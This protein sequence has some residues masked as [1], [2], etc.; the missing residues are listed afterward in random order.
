MRL[1]TFFLDW[2]L[3]CQFAGPIWAR[4][5]G[6]YRHQGLE[7]KLLPPSAQTQ[8]SL[9]DLVLDRED[10]V[11]SIEDNLIVRAALSRKPVRAI[12]CMLN[13]TPLV[14]M[15]AL[16]GPIKTLLD[17]PGH[18][19]AMHGD[20]VHLLKTLLKLNGLDL[21]SVRLQADH[22]SLDNLIEGRLD[23]LQGYAITEARTLAEQGFE[24]RL[25]PLRHPDLNPHSQV[26]FASLQTIA[27][28]KK[29]LQA[30]LRATFEGWRQVLAQP[31][32]AAE[33]IAEHSSEHRDPIQNWVILDTIGRY[34]SAEEASRPL[35]TLD[36]ERWRRN[37]KS[38]ARCGIAAQVA[39]INL[40]IEPHLFSH[41]SEQ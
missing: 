11:G 39:D 6:L 14:L 35:G 34:V 31:G 15:T 8:H 3:N 27:H 16:G 40:V 41:S 25:I 18:R 2:E 21:E 7:V 37:L 17:L 4:E 12:A 28:R 33:L 19:V 13:E 30:F 32:E 23:A 9:I 22:A 29:D 38:Y 1:I 10:A 36:P 5:K 26:I 20:G 24:A